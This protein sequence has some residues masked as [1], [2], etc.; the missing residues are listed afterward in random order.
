MNNNIKWILDYEQTSFG[1]APGAPAPKSGTVQA[2]DERVLM[3]R[4]QFAF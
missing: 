4:L 3:A 2:Q 1:F